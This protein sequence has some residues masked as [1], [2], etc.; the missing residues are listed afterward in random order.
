MRAPGGGETRRSRRR[1][2]RRRR[3]VVRS[4]VV[5]F[6]PASSL[7]SPY[8]LPSFP[9]PSSSSAPVDAREQLPRPQHPPSPSPPPP[10][11]PRAV[12]LVRMHISV[13]HILI[14][15]V[16]TRLSSAGYHHQDRAI[17]ATTTIILWLRQGEYPLART[18]TN[19]SSYNHHYH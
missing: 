6:V 7:I 17:A 3:T 11:S 10:Q 19:S 13:P 8:L 4:R 16:I 12:V 15:G 14:Q 18:H 9:S 1:R 2:R 5:I